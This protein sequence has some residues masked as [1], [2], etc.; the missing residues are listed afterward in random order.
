MTVNDFPVKVKPLPK[1]EGQLIPSDAAT[2]KI[3]IDSLY[4]TF[5]MSSLEAQLQPGGD[6]KILGD[7]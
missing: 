2:V 4:T 7:I 5:K 1:T 3:K 6:S